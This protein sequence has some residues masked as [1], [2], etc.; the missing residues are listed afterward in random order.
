[1]VS[2][3]AR[4]AAE[5][6]GG[7]VRSGAPQPLAAPSESAAH[8]AAST[9]SGAT[10]HHINATSFHRSRRACT[11]NEF[12]QSASASLS[13]PDLGHAP[14]A[15]AAGRHQLRCPPS[16]SAAAAAHPATTHS[17][18]RAAATAAAADSSRDAAFR[19]THHS[20][21]ARRASGPTAASESSRPRHPRSAPVAQV[22]RFARNS[23]YRLEKM[24]LS[25]N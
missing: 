10:P 18:R 19:A 4:H 6:P 23:K 22:D 3:R 20:G 13:D 16:R 11:S 1:M 17:A 15:A 9:H 8:L 5:E 2:G 12:N 14:A 24:C 7:A 21:S 25:R